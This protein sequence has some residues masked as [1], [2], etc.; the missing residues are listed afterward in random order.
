MIKEYVTIKIASPK[1]ILSW[2][3]RMLPN[4]KLVGE[5]SKSVRNM[6]YK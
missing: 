4:G 2:T 6:F 1:K 3:E 5:I